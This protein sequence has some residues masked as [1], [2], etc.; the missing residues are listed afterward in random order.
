MSVGF[1]F[2]SKHIIR[3]HSLHSPSESLYVRLHKI[4]LTKQK[5]G[6][7]YC[8]HK[9]EEMASPAKKA[10]ASTLPTCPYGA[11]CYR[12]N[13]EHFKEFLHPPKQTTDT[14][15]TSN[16]KDQDNDSKKTNTKTTKPSLPD[17]K[18]LPPCKYGASCFRKNLLHF[19]EFS[20]P[21]AVVKKVSSGSGS[22]TD[23]IDSDDEKDEVA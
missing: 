11:R 2:E 19:A 17:D 10:K 16:S 14:A 6:K 22:D 18:N 3:V 15:S 21:T 8:I 12:K 7:F 23:P 9:T 13:P 5:L 4:I 1:V 20:H